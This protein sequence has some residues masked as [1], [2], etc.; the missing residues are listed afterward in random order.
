MELDSEIQGVGWGEPVVANSHVVG[1]ASSQHGRACKAIPVSFIRMILQARQEAGPH[2][3]GYFHFYWQ[4]AENT[5]SLA[6]LRLPGKGRGVLVINVPERPDDEPQ[7]LQPRDVILQIDGFDVDIQGDYTDPEFGALMLENLATRNKWA[8]DDVRMK[9]WRDGK[10]LDVT[11]RL[12]AFEYSHSRVPTGVYDQPPDYLIV[13]GLV[14]QP[15]TVPYLQ[16][17]GEEWLR[18]APFRLAYYTGDDATRE[19]P[20]LVILSQVLPDAF[21]LGYQEQRGLAVDKVNGRRVTSLAELREAL[22]RPKDDYHV[23][24]FVPNEST[25]RVV[26]AAG[27]AEQEA[28]GRVLERFGIS[29]ASQIAP[30]AGPVK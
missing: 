26:L 28:T 21:N 19:Q 2:R 5:A 17:W 14:F 9:I 1:M 15:L 20:A 22:T 16:R 6:F 29:S 18:R 24:D 8:G 25:Q 13:G 3:L 23:F 7:V 30:K 10:T 27:N 4:R 12:P 11:Y